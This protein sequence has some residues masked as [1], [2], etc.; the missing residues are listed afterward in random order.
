M[1]CLQIVILVLPF[2]DRT[3]YHS[4]IL[5]RSTSL[6]LLKSVFL[7]MQ[8]L[9]VNNRITSKELQ[10]KLVKELAADAELSEEDAQKLIAEHL[11][12]IAAAEKIHDDEKS[13][14]IMALEMRLVERKALAQQIVSGRSFVAEAARPGGGGGWQGIY[15]QKKLGDQCPFQPAGKKFIFTFYRK[16]L[17]N[18]TEIIRE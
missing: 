16:V 9:S 14:Q 11:E 8:E 1:Q 15:P 13:R 3:F 17:V 18:T 4:H 12:A 10:T 2:S 6:T 7:L 5:I